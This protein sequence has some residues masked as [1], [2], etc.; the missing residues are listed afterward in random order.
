MS[1]PGPLGQ[2]PPIRLRCRTA[3]RPEREIICP[4]GQTVLLCG[5]EFRYDSPPAQR[6]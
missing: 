5:I 3:D 1:V 2:R 4:P 6:L